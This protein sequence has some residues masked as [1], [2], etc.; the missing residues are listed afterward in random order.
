MNF[1][2]YKKKKPTFHSNIFQPRAEAYDYFSS[3]RLNEYLN[4]WRKK[5]SQNEIKKMFEKCQT[6]DPLLQKNNNH[7]KSI[8]GKKDIK[9]IEAE[10]TTTTTAP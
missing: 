1:K 4:R 3:F 2:V 6:T 9:D 5:N 7:K 10:M 8:K